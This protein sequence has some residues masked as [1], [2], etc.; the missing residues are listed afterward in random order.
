MFA[1]VGLPEYSKKK[2]DHSFF[3]SPKNQKCV[4]N[5]FRLLANIFCQSCP[6]ASCV[7]NTVLPHDYFQV[8]TIALVDC[9]H[10]SITPSPKSQ[11]LHWWIA[12][13]DR[14]FSRYNKDLANW[15]HFHRSLSR[16]TRFLQIG[17]AIDQSVAYGIAPRSTVVHATKLAMFMASE[18]T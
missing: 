2:M 10:R 4:V 17:H 8:T 9:I 14:S 3:L 6:I 11:T 12:S 18:H 15:C 16:G 5:N 13:I 1:K 7:I